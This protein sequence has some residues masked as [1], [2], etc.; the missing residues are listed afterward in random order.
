[1]VFM[2]RLKFFAYKPTCPISA[3]FE[4]LLPQ[5]LRMQATSALVRVVAIA[6]L[7]NAMLV[8]LAQHPLLLR[9]SNLLAFHSIHRRPPPSMPDGKPAFAGGGR[10]QIPAAAEGTTQ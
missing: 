8:T 10:P 1:M 9:F 3:N 2:Q 7:C 5:R 6:S 4:L